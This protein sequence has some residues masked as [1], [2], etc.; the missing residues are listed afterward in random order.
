MSRKLL[1]LWVSKVGPA[2]IGRKERLSG[3][4]SSIYF[5]V[6]DLHA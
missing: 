4:S 3:G 5:E 1:N 6:E 2:T